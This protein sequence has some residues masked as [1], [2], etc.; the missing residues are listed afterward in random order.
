MFG[1]SHAEI[2]RKVS[3]AANKKIVKDL[4]CAVPGTGTIWYNQQ[5]KEWG[6]SPD[7]QLVREL[8]AAGKL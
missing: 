6:F 5:T 8:R 2:E 7:N 1:I 4:K 3:E